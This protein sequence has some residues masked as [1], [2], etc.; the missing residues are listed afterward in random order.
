MLRGHKACQIADELVEGDDETFMT[1]VCNENVSVFPMNVLRAQQRTC[2]QSW[3]LQLPPIRSPGP[4]AA[5]GTAKTRCVSCILFCLKEGQF[6]LQVFCEHLAQ[7]IS[8]IQICGWNVFLTRGTALKYVLLSDAVKDLE[9]ILSK[10]FLDIKHDINE[11]GTNWAF[12]EKLVSD[13]MEFL[14]LTKT[15]E[16]LVPFPFISPF[17]SQVTFAVPLQDTDLLPSAE[18]YRTDL[19]G[20]VVRENERVVTAVLEGVRAGNPEKIEGA[21]SATR[22]DSHYCLLLSCIASLLPSLP[23][24]VWKALLKMDA[25]RQNCTSR[26]PGWM[27]SSAVMSKGICVAKES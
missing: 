22:Q 21:S 7:S 1:R 9:Q 8:W 15:L 16:E 20:Q 25:F 27:A 18:S 26:I 19:I 23:V 6:V 4:L 13:V 3:L 24:G 14:N 17:L 5:N 11:R 12:A 2:F 10:F